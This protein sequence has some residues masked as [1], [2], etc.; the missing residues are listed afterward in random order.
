MKLL[1]ALAL[2]LIYLRCIV[3]SLTTIDGILFEIVAVGFD[4]PFLIC[5][6]LFVVLQK[7]FYISLIKKK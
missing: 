2:E 3:S 6:G 4:S 5:F 1:F 7:Y